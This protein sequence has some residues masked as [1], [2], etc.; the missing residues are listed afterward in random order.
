M[1]LDKRKIESL[2]N[3]EYEEHKKLGTLSH[4]LVPLADLNALHQC[5]ED[6][7]KWKE[8]KDALREM[9][10][11]ECEGGG[12]NPCS[13]MWYQDIIESLLAE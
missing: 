2:L 8:A 10:Q 9:L 11:H 5:A 7:L 4:Y 3:A 6:A 1:T 12:D 13:Q